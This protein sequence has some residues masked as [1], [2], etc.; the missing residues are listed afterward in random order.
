MKANNVS[1]ALV[2]NAYC[3]GFGKDL[4][5]TLSSRLNADELKIFYNR[6]GLSGLDGFF[7]VFRVK[8]NQLKNKNS[9]YYA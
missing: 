3:T 4:A 9:D 5:T 2:A 6:A 8:N 1:F 7:D